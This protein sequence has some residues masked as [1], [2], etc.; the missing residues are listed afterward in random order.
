MTVAW[1]TSADMRARRNERVLEM[2]ARGRTALEIA[3]TVNTSRATV[4]HVLR[5]AWRAGDKRARPS[6]SYVVW[7]DRELRECP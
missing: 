3:R 6:R 1:H 2:W 7:H 4:Y 5:T